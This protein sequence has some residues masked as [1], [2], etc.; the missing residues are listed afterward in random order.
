MKLRAKKDF[1]ISYNRNDEGWA[2]WIAWQLEEAGYTTVIQK[3]DMEPG[4]NFIL[5]MQ[6]AAELCERTLIVLS[7]HFLAA[8]YTQ[9]E[10]AQAFARDPTGE[11]RLLIPV[12]VAE[13]ELKGFFKPLVYIDFYPLC[14]EP[15][16]G[17]SAQRELIRQLRYRLLK[18]VELHRRK[19]DSEPRPPGFGDPLGGAEETTPDSQEVQDY[20]DS[21][22]EGVRNIDL[23][24]LKHLTGG[25]PFPIDQVYIP[26]KV[27][28]RLLRVEAT[29]DRQLRYLAEDQKEP[30]ELGELL[31]RLFELPDYR[32]ML[33]LG[34]PG[35]GKTTLLKYLAYHYASGRQETIAPGL[36]ARVPFFVRLKD[37]AT[38]LVGKSERDYPTLAEVIRSNLQASGS[39]LA[40]SPTQLKL[41]LRGKVLVLLDGL[42]E[43]TDK[44]QRKTVADWVKRAVKNHSEATFIISSRVYGYNPYYAPDQHFTVEVDDLN[45]SQRADLVHR[46]FGHVHRQRQLF[47]RTL[48]W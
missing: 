26:L 45:I 40:P 31:T 8:E 44:V 5:E 17:E 22:V 20:L 16:K 7:P 33:V 2:E 28:P 9:P 21:L 32:C 39:T 35:A 37:V 27:N 18:G 14:K 24:H 6:R 29:E 36:R 47:S 46:W 41:W 4:S 25:M 12:R 48:S 30:R 34:K 19:P 3:W 11:K 38:E 10:W 23:F 15:P 13:C 1:F 43:V 42:D